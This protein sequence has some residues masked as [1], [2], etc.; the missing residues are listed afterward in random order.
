M[1]AKPK[2]LVIDDEPGILEMIQGHFSLRGFDVFT[3]SD[4]RI[5]IE[6]CRRVMPDVILLDLK[7]KEM[8]G[9]AALPELRRLVP[10]AKIFV[11]SAY[12]DEVMEK[13]IRGL[14]VTAHFE[15]PVSIIEIEKVIRE[16]VNKPAFS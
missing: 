16:A 1:T 3:A 5:G 12:Q 11:I 2:I 9:D 15:K 4:G 6:E 7:M 13:R 10:N 14:G 8:D